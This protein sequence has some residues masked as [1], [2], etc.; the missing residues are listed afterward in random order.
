MS[1]YLIPTRWW[2]CLGRIMWYGFV[3]ENIVTRDGL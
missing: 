3:E 1:E 2:D